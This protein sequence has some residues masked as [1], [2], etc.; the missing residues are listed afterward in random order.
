MR[1]VLL[2][3]SIQCVPTEE[4]KESYHIWKVSG[5]SKRSGKYPVP[6]KADELS[7]LKNYRASS[8]PS[9]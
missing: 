7:T 9:G 6:V 5:S 1:Q 8:V 3:H 2:D 4:E